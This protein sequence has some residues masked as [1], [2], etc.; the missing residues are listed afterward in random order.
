MIWSGL[1]I[2]FIAWTILNSVRDSFRHNVRIQYNS[3]DESFNIN[4]FHPTSVE[5]VCYQF[6]WVFIFIAHQF[7]VIALNLELTMIDNQ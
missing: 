3:F 4:N 5:N 6:N 1:H 7:S 2:F